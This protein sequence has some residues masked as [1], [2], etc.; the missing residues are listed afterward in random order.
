M[1]GAVATIAIAVPAIASSAIYNYTVDPKAQLLAQGTL[2]TLSGTITCDEGDQIANYF[3]VTEVV[4]RTL[5]SAEASIY[6]NWIACT[7]ALQPWSFT[8]RAFSTLPFLP[9]R[10]GEH[11]IPFDTFDFGVGPDNNQPIVLSP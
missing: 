3:Q 9:G 2:V 6:P 10:A 8:L 4:G 11:S 7:G 5:R 1:A